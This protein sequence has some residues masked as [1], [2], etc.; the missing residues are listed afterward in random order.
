MSPAERV[1]RSLGAKNLSRG[2]P[3]VILPENTSRQKRT[4]PISPE[5][6]ETAIKVITKK[7]HGRFEPPSLAKLGGPPRRPRRHSTAT[8]AT[9]NKTNMINTRFI[10]IS[11]HNVK[12]HRIP[13]RERALISDLQVEWPWRTRLGAGQG[14][15][16]ASCSPSCWV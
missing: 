15:C 1:L 11:R 9:E 13:D 14:F 12:A 2:Y 6:M 4:I 3:A 7:N 16:A 8:V 10:R 5:I